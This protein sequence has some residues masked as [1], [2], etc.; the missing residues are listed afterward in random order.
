LAKFTAN[1][2]ASSRD[3]RF[4][5]IC[6][7]GSSSKLEVAQRLAGLVLD[8]EAL[9][10]LFDRPGWREATLRQSGRHRSGFL[11]SIV[12]AHGE[13]M[14]AAT[15]FAKMV[16]TGQGR[17]VIGKPQLWASQRWR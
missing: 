1:R 16:R 9:V 8:D 11:A 15:A 4:I 6:R 17:H 14:A 12:A 13:K 3:S 2:N 5:D 10:V 7:C